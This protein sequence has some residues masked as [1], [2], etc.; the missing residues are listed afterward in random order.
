MT[1]SAGGVHNPF[2]A[3]AEPGVDEWVVVLEFSPALGCRAC[4]YGD[5]E[6][7]LES[8]REWRPSGLWSLGR[9]A[10]QL[11]IPASTPHHAVRWA[12][13]YHEQA[14]KAVGLP[15]ADLNRVEVFTLE[16]LEESWL[17]ADLTTEGVTTRCSSQPLLYD[18]VYTATRGLLAA[19]TA[20]EVADIVAGFVTAAGGRVEPGP[21]AHLPGIFDI[22]MTIEAGRATHAWAEAV[23]V[24][25]LVVEQ[26]LPVLL[27]DARCALLRF[28]TRDR[29]GEFEQPPA[30]PGTT[31]GVA[32]GE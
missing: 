25:R 18:E 24:A 14:A 17:E 32:L 9:Y 22:D 2:V 28:Q 8:L 11:H 4:L 1:P 16:V 7:L 26:L 29:K 31:A 10:V 27:A 20:T 5:V 6:A 12:L 15:L 13:A 3:P 30:H 19:T 21:V 23:S